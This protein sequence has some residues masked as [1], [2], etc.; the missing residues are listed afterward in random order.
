VIVFALGR[1]LL[2]G[3]HE[4]I[5]IFFFLGIIVL[6]I[7]SAAVMWLRKISANLNRPPGGSP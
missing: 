5:G 3:T 2:E 7:F 1:A 4:P 6:G